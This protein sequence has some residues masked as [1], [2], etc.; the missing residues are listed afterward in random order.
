MGPLALVGFLVLVWALGGFGFRQDL[1]TVTAPGAAIATGPYEFSFTEATVQHRRSD[2][3]YRVVVSGQGRTTGDSSIRPATGDSGFLAARGETS[4]EV[5]P[6][7]S[8]TLG[9]PDYSSLQLRLFTPGLGAAPVY[10]GFEFAAD[11]GDR[12][13]MVVFGQKFTTPYVLSDERGW[14]RTRDSHAVVL[15]LR[16]LPES[17]Y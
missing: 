14:Q 5:Q 3:H 1:T 12:I 6:A 13:R 10:V 11:P 9:S 7:T 16:V 8:V 17:K 15:R 4:R 2:D